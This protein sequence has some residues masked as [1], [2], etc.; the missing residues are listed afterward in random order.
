MNPELPARA[1]ETD[2]PEGGGMFNPSHLPSP[3]RRLPRR[4]FRLLHLMALIAAVALTLVIPSALMKVIMQ[5]LSCWGPQEQLAYKTSLA[6]TFW[7]PIL[8]ILAVISNRS[9]LA[10]AS[11][12][13]GSS[14]ILAAA[15]AIFVL[16]VRGLHSTLLGYFHGVSF[17]PD[18]GSYYGPTARCLVADAPAAAAAATV[19]VWLVLALTGAGQRPSDWFDRF[20]F[21]FGLLWL[22][23][24]L[25]RALILALPGF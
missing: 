7:S 8:A 22:L 15:T 17:F 21:F 1:W 23:R 6:L 3:G 13:Y 18:S 2:Y 24:Y 9:A 19:A 14:A 16:F 25:G 11:R 4:P 12:S 20:C 5:P 10:Q